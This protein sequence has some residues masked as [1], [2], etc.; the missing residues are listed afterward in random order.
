M[1]PLV[2]PDEFSEVPT[3]TTVPSLRAVTPS[4]AM[5][6]LGVATMLQLVQFHCSAANPTA[7]MSLAE[8]AA[9]PSR[10]RVVRGF[11]SGLGTTRKHVPSQCSINAAEPWAPTAHT[12]LLATA[13]MPLR[14]ERPPERVGVWTTLQLAPLK[15][16][17]SVTSWLD[18]AAGDGEICHDCDP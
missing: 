12:S 11:G 5:T 1:T 17:A 13:A 16:S 2:T 6:P 10:R 8:M 7:Q 14:V 18:V 9:I 3:A 15:C 4:S